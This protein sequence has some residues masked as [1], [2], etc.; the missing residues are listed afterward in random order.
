M[1]VRVRIRHN[2]KWTN[3]NPISSF[4]CIWISQWEVVTDQNGHPVVILGDSLKS[5][6]GTN[7]IDPPLQPVEPG[8]GGLGAAEPDERHGLGDEDGVV[9]ALSQ[10]PVGG[11][12]VPVHVRRRP[13]EQR[14]EANPSLDLR[15]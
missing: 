10:L 7:V 12:Q 5:K 8:E 2:F 11:V 1:L 9:G 3:I 13:R 15:V 14:V 4:N 6:C